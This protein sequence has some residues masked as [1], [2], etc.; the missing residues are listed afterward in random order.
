MNITN[1]TYNIKT[2][3]TCDGGIRQNGCSMVVSDRMVAAR[4]CQ[5]E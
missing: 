5:T 2:T 1:M 3:V 4:W